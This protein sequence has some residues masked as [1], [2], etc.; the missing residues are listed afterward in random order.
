VVDYLKK[1]GITYPQLFDGK[2]KDAGIQSIYKMGGRCFVFIIDR[3]GKVFAKPFDS[4][5]AEPYIKTALAQR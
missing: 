4:K 1:T 5:E 2:G 3:Q